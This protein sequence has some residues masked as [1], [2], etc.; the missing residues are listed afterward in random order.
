MS[1]YYQKIISDETI[2]EVQKLISKGK[3][4][5]EIKELTGVSD[6][7]I[8]RIKKGKITVG[9]NINNCTDLISIDEVHILNQKLLEANKKLMDQQHLI[10][11]LEKI[12]KT[13]TSL[14]DLE[15][16]ALNKK[17]FNYFKNTKFGRELIQYVTTQAKIKNDKLYK[18]NQELKNYLF[19]KSNKI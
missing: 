7:T 18:E 8:T 10:S 14:F 13:K 16:E 11:N 15:S 12:I 4:Y 6:G 3:T 9:R 17:N 5:K 2:L 1:Y 19:E